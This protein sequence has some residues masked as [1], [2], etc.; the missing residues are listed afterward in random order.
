[1]DN[2][3]IILLSDNFLVYVRIIIFTKE[4]TLKIDINHILTVLC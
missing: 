2:E 4:D 1:M 3:N